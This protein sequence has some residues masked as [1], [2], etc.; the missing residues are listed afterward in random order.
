MEKQPKHSRAWW[1]VA[2]SALSLLVFALTG[3][4]ASGD[5]SS[6]TNFL[7]PLTLVSFVSAAIALGT[8]IGA[9]VS[10]YINPA[11][12]LAMKVAGP[13]VLVVVFFTLSPF[14]VALGTIATR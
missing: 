12:T 6:L 14:L 2:V 8:A 3:L 9:N 10:A 13:I 5:S 11:S 4:V 7:N 1:F